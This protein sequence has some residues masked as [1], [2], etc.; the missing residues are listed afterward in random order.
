MAVGDG[1][2]PRHVRD[3][4]KSI[5]AFYM[6]DNDDGTTVAAMDLRVP[7]VGERHRRLAARGA[8]PDMLKSKMAAAGLS[9]ADYWWYLDLR[10]YGTVPHAGYGLGFERL[11]CY[12]TGVPNIREAQRAAAPGKLR[13]LRFYQGAIAHAAHTPTTI[14][15]P[16]HTLDLYV[17]TQL[18]PQQEDRT[19]PPPASDRAGTSPL[20]TV[21]VRER[22]SR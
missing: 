17:G 10:R 9:E 6:R 1:V 19:C 15:A 13:V 7:G 11:V 4:P 16:R 14:R 21:A 12:V 22:R 18:V 5:K 2:R 8:P 20:I 3:Y